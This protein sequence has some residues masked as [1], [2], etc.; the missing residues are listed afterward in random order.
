VSSTNPARRRSLARRRWHAVTAVVAA[1]AAVA[2]VVFATTPASASPQA[3]PPSAAQVRAASSPWHC[4]QVYKVPSSDAGTKIAFINP[5]PADPYV[6]EWSKGYA[7]AAKYYHLSLKESF[8]GNYN[9]SKLVD[10]YRALASFNPAV[11]GALGDAGTGQALI[12]AVKADHRKLVFIDTEVPGGIQIGLPNFQGGQ[13]EGRSLQKSVTPLLSGAWKG[14]KIVVVGMS[15]EGCQPCEERVNGAFSVLKKFL[16]KSAQYIKVEDTGDNTAKT[17]TKMR[18]II[19]AHP[20]AAFIVA[21]LDDETGGGSFNAIRQ[22]GVEKYARLATI[23]GDNLAVANLSKGS[24]TYV[25]SV[26]AVPFCEAWNWVEAAMAVKDGKKFSPYK[27]AGVI[28]PS[29]VA[30]YKWRLKT[31]K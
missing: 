7:A 8:L 6:A 15:L 5:G 20:G 4:S 28:T 25:A 14:R 18:D 26:D 9:F 24:P 13:I 27:F 17:Q 16:P 23:G 31:K 1:T 21:S 29:N 11:V 2:T 30:K 3:G 12:A 22:A 10:S 19:T